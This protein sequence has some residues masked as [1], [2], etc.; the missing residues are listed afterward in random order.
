MG[1]ARHYGHCGEGNSS[2]IFF[3]Y[4]AH[5]SMMNMDENFPAF[6]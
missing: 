5:F 1:S 3:N 2:G 6:L 4:D